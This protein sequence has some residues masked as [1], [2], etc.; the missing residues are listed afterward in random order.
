MNKLWGFFE[1]KRS[2]LP[3][4][5][6]ELFTPGM[7]LDDNLLWT[8]RTAIEHGNDLNLPRK[9]GVTA[10]EAYEA[11]C[12][13]YYIF[14]NLGMVIVYPYFIAEKSGTLQIN[15]KE[16]VIEA[17][18]EDLWNLVSENKKDVTYYDSD[19]SSFTDGNPSF[20]T[21]DELKCLKSQAHKA[22][23]IFRQDLAENSSILLEW[24]FA[25]NTNIQ[26]EKIGEKYLVFYE[27]RSL[28]SYDKMYDTL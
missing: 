20:L 26:K 12:N 18:N 2:G 15:N 21:E 25:Y 4:V 16:L 17:V 1:L 6:W 13:F 3:S 10:K 9:V 19:I 24:S 28:R 14:E 8:V 27:A 23:L 11:A 22:R 5:K 7:K